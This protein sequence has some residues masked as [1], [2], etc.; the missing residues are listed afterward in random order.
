MSSAT[1]WWLPSAATSSIQPGSGFPPPTKSKSKPLTYMCPRRSMAISSTAPAVLGLRAIGGMVVIS[2]PVVRSEPSGSQSIDQPPSD[3]GVV[4]RPSA[5]TRPS[6]ST[7]TTSPVPHRRTTSGRL[8]VARTRPWT[9]P[10]R[11]AVPSRD[12]TLI[13]DSSRL[14]WTGQSNRARRSSRCINQGRKVER[15]RGPQ[16]TKHAGIVAAAKA[17]FL[18]EGFGGGGMDVIATGSG[19][20]EQTI[21]A[22][23]G[24]KEALFAAT[25]AE[26]RRRSLGSCQAYPTGARPSRRRGLVIRLCGTAIAPGTDARDRATAPARHRRGRPVPRDGPRLLRQWRTAIDRPP[27]GGPRKSSPTVCSPSTTRPRRRTTR[28]LLMGQPVN[29]AMMLG[30]SSTPGARRCA[31][32]PDAR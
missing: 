18:R 1:R 17:T 6:R 28:W 22:H 13:G 15:N 14:D 11:E 30:S 32:T 29:Q 3:P 10:L 23:F 19:G 21:S 16:R 26:L 12:A 31:R 27:H 20:S 7:A 25:V 5:C 4:P 24:S 9:V 2:G 8:A